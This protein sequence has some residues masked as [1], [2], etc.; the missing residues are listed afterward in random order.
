MLV[1]RDQSHWVPPGFPQAPG[2]PGAAW[3]DFFPGLKPQDPHQGHSPGGAGGPETMHPEPKGRDPESHARS[4]WTPHPVHTGI[5]D[6]SLSSD[7]RLPPPPPCGG[8]SS[9]LPFHRRGMAD[10]TSPTPPPPELSSQRARP[11]SLL[12]YEGDACTPLEAIPIS[13]VRASPPPQPFSW[14]RHRPPI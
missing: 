3:C 6:S 2:K 10:G 8:E 14:G 12:P 1:S 9:V 4:T 13:R 11:H 7:R 5:P